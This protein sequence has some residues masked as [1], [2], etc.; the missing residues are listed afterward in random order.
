MCSIDSRR[1][2]GWRCKQVDCDDSEQRVMQIEDEIA[3]T[4]SDETARVATS[5]TATG[6]P[7][8]GKGES[9]DEGSMAATTS[10]ILDTSVSSSRINL[11]VVVGLELTI[12]LTAGTRPADEPRGKY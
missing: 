3:A 4:T 7:P 11:T 2:S 1:A 10:T 8:K 5:K 6:Q 9:Q 12:A